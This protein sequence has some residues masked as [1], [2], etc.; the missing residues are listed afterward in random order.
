MVTLF[1]VIFAAYTISIIYIYKYRGNERYA[2]FG[3]YIRKGWPIFA[4]FNCFLYTQTKAEGRKPIL[5]GDFYDDLKVIRENWETIRDE[6]VALNEDKVFATAHDP[7]SAAHYDIGFRTFYKRGWSKFY[8]SWYGYTHDSAKRLCPKTVEILKDLKTINGSMFSLLPPGGELTRHLD[9]FACSYRYHLGLNTPNSDD[10]FIEVDQNKQSWRDGEAFMFDETFIHF[11]ENNSDKDRLILMCDVERPMGIL[12]RLFNKLYKFSM[13][14]MVVPNTEE[15]KKGGGNRIFI[16]L[17]SFFA[18]SKAL[19][20]KNRKLY[21]VVKFI[22][23]SLLVVALIGLLY[24]P[25][26]LITS[27]F[28]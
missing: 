15:D 10:C 21:K 2:S 27:V 8:I 3:E 26:Y 6:A 19:K 17:N 22:F 28:S 23:N 4:P 14:W 9:P 5:S 18:M 25:Y 20:K 7:D 24:L 1:S 12:G 16:K 13:R 11:A